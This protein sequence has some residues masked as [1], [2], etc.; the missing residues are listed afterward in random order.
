MPSLSTDTDKADDE[1]T[2]QAAQNE[3]QTGKDS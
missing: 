2:I 3:K 1:A